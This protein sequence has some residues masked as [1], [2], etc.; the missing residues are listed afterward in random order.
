MWDT[1]SLL[2][3]DSDQPLYPIRGWSQG[4]RLLTV[5]RLRTEVSRTSPQH[6]MCQVVITVSL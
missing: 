2:H 3:G 1:V 4:V 6:A 5:D